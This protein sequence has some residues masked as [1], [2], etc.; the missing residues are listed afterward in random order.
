MATRSTPSSLSPRP[1]HRKAM[2]LAL[3]ILSL[4][5]CGPIIPPFHWNMDSSGAD[6]GQASAVVA[7]AQDDGWA[8]DAFAVYGQ[9]A[10][11]T[12]LAAFR[13]DLAH[14]EVDG[15]VEE[16]YRVHLSDFMCS[17]ARGQSAEACPEP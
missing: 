16:N 17:C 9:D 5:G 8:S 6:A 13:Q 7:H 14:G 4:A 11:H 10:V 1:P 3:G 15:L 2:L 12:C